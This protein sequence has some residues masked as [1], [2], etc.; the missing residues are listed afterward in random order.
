VY[1]ELGI[2]RVITDG[3]CIITC[4]QHGVVGVLAFVLTL[5]GPGFMFVARY[6]PRRW[7]EPD[8]GAMAATSS[9]LAMYVLDCMFNAFPNGVY[10]VMAGAMTSA[11]MDRSRLLA[12]A[13]WDVESEAAPDAS[14]APPTAEERLAARYIELA[15]NARRIGDFAAAAEARRLAYD[16]LV[17]RSGLGV[18][19]PEAR[20]RRLDCGNDLAW[21]LA[22]RPDPEAGD[23]EEAVELARASA[24]AEPDEPSYWNTLAL[25]LSRAGYDDDALAASQRSMELEPSWNAYDLAV[26]A[27]ALARLG[28][29]DEAGRWLAEAV[30]RRDRHDPTLDALMAEA[31]AALGS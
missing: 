4:G 6:H 30:A 12:A 24:E 7:T 9:L 25:A 23:R 19:T 26:L 14:T 2:D 20:R 3:Y 15:R 27:L 31:E 16:L 28:R 5:V 18:E 13:G 10:M 11:T 22:T 1:D 17:R 8:I 29:R 21:L